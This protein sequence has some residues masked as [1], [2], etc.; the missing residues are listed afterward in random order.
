M[1]L[2]SA[3]G[4][5]REVKRRRVFFGVLSMG[6]G[7]ISVALVQLAMVPAL[8][9]SWGLPLYGQWLLLVTVPTVLAVSDLGFGSAAGNRLIGEVARG[10]INAARVT[11]QSALVVV[12]VCSATTLAVI[13]GISALLPSR[14]LAVSGGMDAQAAREVLMVFGFYGVALMQSALFIAVVRAYGRFALS[15]SFEATVLLAEGLTVIAVALSGGTPLNAACGYLVVRTLGVAGHVML[16]RHCAKWLVLGFRDATRARMSELLRPALA[17][18]VMPLAQAGYLQGTALAVG[19]A[20]GAAAVPVFTSL[21]TLSRAVLQFVMAVNVPVLPEF[22]AEHSR[23]NLSW[24]RR[25]TGALT[26]FNGFAGA[27]GGL[28]LFFSGKSLLD[29]W[30]RGAIE[31]PQAMIYL[32]AVSLFAG[33]IW[34]PMSYFLLAVNRHESFAYTFGVAACLT[35]VLSYFL[36]RHWGITG[37]A[38]ANLLLDLAMAGFV[39]V[40]LRLLN[41]PFPIG[42]SAIQMLAPPSWR[43]SARRT[44]RNEPTEGL[45]D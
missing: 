28:A 19:A 17:A 26:T 37:A 43:R 13:L 29:L 14:L 34:T 16:A 9:T 11:F 12:L 23:G 4:K 1:T 40:Q 6:Y 24:I 22:T 3:L 7:K 33:A 31:A 15:T 39:L 44:A 27:I 30:T 25:T 35:I 32:T 41:G 18:M 20:A 2:P 45:P 21:R 5:A 36:V 10:D 42:L 38:F 8:A